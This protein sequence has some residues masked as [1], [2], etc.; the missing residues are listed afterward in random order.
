M[1]FVFARNPRWRWVRP[2]RRSAWSWFPPALALAFGVPSAVQAVEPV[3]AFVKGLQDRGLHELAL[4]YLDGLKTSPLAD[5]ATRRHVPYQRGVALIEQSRASADSATRI[6]LLDEARKELEQFA[7]ANP[8]NVHGAEAQLQLANVQM[9][10]G[11]ELVAQ[12]AQLAKD[13]S[14]DAQRKTLGRDAQLRFAEARDTYQRAESTYSKELESLPPTASSELQDDAGSQRQEYRSRVA[15]LRFLAAQAQ[16]ESAQSYPREADEFRKLNE[17]AAQELSAIYDEFGRTLLVGL[18]ARLFEGRCYQAMGN[19]QLALGCY[20]ELLGKDNLLPAFRKLTA[21]TLLRKAEV[22]IAQEKYD[23]AIEVCNLCL[24]GG[25]KDEEKQPEWIAVRFRLAEAL[26]KKAQALTGESA[27]QRKLLTEAREA[28]RLVAKTPGEFQAA[29]RAATATS[30][31]AQTG[32]GAQKDEPK[33]FQAAY[34][35]GNEALSSYNSAKL[36]IPSAEKNNPPAVPELQGQ[37]EQGKDDARRYFRLA[38]TLVTDDTDPKQLNEVRYFLC[39][40]YWEAEDFYRAAVLGEFIARHYSDHPAA[41]S[42]AKI[43][44]A[45]YE[46]LFNLAIAASKNKEDGEFESRQMAQMAEFIVRRWPGTDAADSAFGVLVSFAIRNGRTDDAEKML[47]ETSAQSRPR[48]ELLLGNALWGRYLELSQSGQATP[49]DAD[50]LAKLKASAVKYLHDGFEVAR[51]ESPVGDAG[52]TAGLY[53]VQALLSDGNY[54]DAIELLEENKSGP[55]GLIEQQHPTA[56]KPQY[57]IEAYKA[58]LRAYVSVTP[59]QENKA[60]STMQSLEKLVRATGGD[61]A[62]TTDQLTRIYIGMGVALQ[63]QMDDLRA[64]G[65]LQEANRVASAYAKFLD[66][67]SAQQGDANWPTRVWLAQTYYAMG[68]DP[69]KTVVTAP[70]VLGKPARDYLTKSRDAYQQLLQGAAKNPK[71]APNDTAVLAAK[72]QLGECYRALGQY[73]EALDTFSAVLKEKEASLAVQRAAALAYQERGQREDAKYLENAIH[74]GVKLKSTGQNRIWGWLRISQVA[75][76]AAHSDEKFRD[77]FYEARYNI[78]R[79]RYMAAL[80]QTGDARQNDLTKARQGIQSLAQLYPEQ[81]GEKW[82]SEFDKLMKQ[83]QTAEAATPAA[84]KE[85]S[86][87]STSNS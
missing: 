14:F 37:M 60:I 54:A 57:S 7:E 3:E 59:P 46:R 38:T 83:I 85:A 24:N 23:A 65:K 79:C 64:S 17:S 61:D 42:A 13:R 69:P 63:K 11:Q 15:Q 87:K 75:G 28:Y 5:E 26:T 9:T 81:G 44:M 72:M 34:D 78:A 53:L 74:G 70:V 22:H 1:G 56:S 35:L 47:Q 48:L 62:K 8:K 51:R 43:S 32:N 41:S 82:K 49:P 6:K 50:A 19:Y 80:K 27:A 18:Y 68:T 67:I 73:Q 2:L 16:F 30:A 25:S 10:R 55:L 33:T 31:Q 71:L 66:R 77:S 52:A 58:A 21:A 20:E 45:A 29:A 4:E 36:A 86:D 76:R 39:W 12:A 84:P 40:L